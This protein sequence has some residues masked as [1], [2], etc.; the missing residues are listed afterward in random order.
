[1]GHF[2]ASERF[3]QAGPRI[4]GKGAGS[5]FREITVEKFPNSWGRG[6]HSVT[7]SL[8][9]PDS[10]RAKQIP[11]RAVIIEVLKVKGRGAEGIENKIQ[12]TLPARTHTGCRW[13]DGNRYPR[14]SDRKQWLILGSGQINFQSKSVTRGKEGTL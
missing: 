11:R 13:R 12:Q 9:T 10:S 14:V 2:R 4:R 1:M 5:L 6:S 8:R 3:Y 7:G